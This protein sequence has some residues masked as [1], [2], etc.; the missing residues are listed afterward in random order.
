MFTCIRQSYHLPAAECR[1]H[2][3]FFDLVPQFHVHIFTCILPMFTC[4][5]QSDHLPVVSVRFTSSSLILFL[6][7]MY[8]Y[9]PVFCLC[10]PVLDNHI[11]YLLL[12]VRFTSSSL[13]LFLSFMYTYLPVF[14]LCL[15]VLD[16]HITYLLLRVRFTSSSLILFLS[17]MYMVSFCIDL[18][19]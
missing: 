2:L 19:F 7:V 10:L 16:N 6:N 5:R 11:T 3:Q 14:Y 4:I 13:I 17:F 8:T 12:S 15:P 18:Y 9:L 1:I